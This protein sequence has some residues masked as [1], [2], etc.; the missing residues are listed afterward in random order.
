MCSRP[1]FQYIPLFVILLSQAT[2]HAVL[3]EGEIAL[4]R[5]QESSFKGLPC[6]RSRTRHTALGPCFLK[7][8]N[9]LLPSQGH[10]PVT[11][12][13]GQHPMV[14]PN[15]KKCSVSLNLLLAYSYLLPSSSIHPYSTYT[16][17]LGWLVHN[18]APAPHILLETPSFR[19][20]DPLLQAYAR[21]HP[22]TLYSYRLRVELDS[23]KTIST[24]RTV[25]CRSRRA[26]TG[27]ARC[28]FRLVLVSKKRE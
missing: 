4:G 11:S 1:S 7:E 19:D 16:Y 14:Q 26:F 25:P 21:P 23:A 27:D 6:F 15:I 12:G 13:R 28:S 9:F 22:P 2:K 5:S 20:N 3:E 24:T 18:P 17:V 10:L 8:T